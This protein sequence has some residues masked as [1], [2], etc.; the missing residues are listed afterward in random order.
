MT[1][2]LHGIRVIKFYSWEKYFL[3]RINDVRTK[4]LSQLKAKKYLDAACVYFW[5]CTPILISVTTFTTYVLIGNKLTPSKVFTSLA[6]FNMLISPLN[7]F[8]WVING[9][10]QANVS[11][12]RVQE[13]LGLANLNW[14][15]F[16]SF[17]DFNVISIC[18]GLSID[19]KDSQMFWK[20]TP[21]NDLIDYVPK[22]VL[23][24]INLKIKKGNSEEDFQIL[25]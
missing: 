25:Q 5:A 15:N 16:Y 18:P 19:I 6:L 21:S 3:T 12:K 20:K 4:E 23:D 10:V 9:L 7:S 13:F 14:L 11:L 2:F 22:V 8:P 24:G 1:E 17:N